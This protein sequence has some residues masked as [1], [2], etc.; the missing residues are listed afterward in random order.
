MI[1]GA[2]AMNCFAPPPPSIT[3]MHHA[4]LEEGADERAHGKGGQG[5]G[6]AQDILG[7]TG[8]MW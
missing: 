1:P 8:I 7:R 5:K 6:E 4:A 3:Q 2:F